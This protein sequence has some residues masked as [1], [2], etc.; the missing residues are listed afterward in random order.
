M[1]RWIRNHPLLDSAHGI[2]RFDL[3]ILL[4]RF[5][6]VL[7]AKG[8]RQIEFMMFIEVKTYGAGLSTSQQDTLSLLNQVL[9]NRRQNM[10]GA[11]RRQVCGQPIV[12]YS[13]AKRK[14]IPLRLLGGHLLQLSGDD[15]D[16]SEWMKWDNT[17]I[18]RDT[19]IELM[20]FARDP[21][22]LAA[23]KADW[24]RRRSAPFATAPKHPTLWESMRCASVD[25]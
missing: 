12:T 18:D 1:E 3:D 6:T 10:H 2:A 8:E 23:R 14:H 15:P 16:N 20:L 4:H 11:P 24:A 22:N 25:T 9:R 17:P 19:L 5:K 7:D 21:D 13:I